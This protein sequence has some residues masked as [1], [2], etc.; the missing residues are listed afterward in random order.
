[1][2]VC[3][4]GGGGVRGPG[5][6]VFREGLLERVGQ[7]RRVAHNQCAY[8]KLVEG[9]AMA[10]HIGGDEEEGWAWARVSMVPVLL[11]TSSGGVTHPTGDHQEQQE[12]HARQQGY[13]QV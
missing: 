8:V 6:G 11:L 9:Q 13:H 1:V 2:Q 5:G 4:C 3:V 12:H 10:R 7:S